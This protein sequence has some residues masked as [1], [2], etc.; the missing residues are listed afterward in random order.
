MLSETACPDKS[1]KSRLAGKKTYHKQTKEEKVMKK[2]TGFYLMFLAIT[3][4]IIILLGTG[5]FAQ[6][7]LGTV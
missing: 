5:L 1:G 4:I 3:S 2:S 6:T 7:N